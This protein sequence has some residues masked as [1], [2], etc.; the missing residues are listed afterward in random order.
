MVYVGTQVSWPQSEARHA[1]D[2]RNAKAEAEAEASKQRRKVQNRKNQ[3]A[4]R[5][6]APRS[7][8]A[9]HTQNP[10]TGL[11]LKGGDAGNRKESRPFLVKRW[12]LDE[13]DPI[14]SQE[15]SPA[16]ERATT[17]AFSHGPPYT[18][19]GISAS[20]AKRT[21]VLRESLFTTTHIQP[22]VNLDIQ[23]FTFPF[24][25]DHLLHLIHYNVCR[26]L[27][28]NMRTLN[29][30]PADSTICTIASPCRDDTTLYPLR[31]DIPSSLIPTAFQQT[32]DHST[33]INV[34]PFPRVREN[35]IRYEGSF[36][37]WE[38]LQDLVGDLLK[39]T[40]DPRQR[41]APTSVKVSRTPQPL[42]FL[43]GTDTDEVTAGRKGLIVWGEPHEMRSWEATPGFLA[44]WAWV[45]EGCDELMEISNHWRM[46]R[47]GGTY[48]A[49]DVEELS[50]TTASA[51]SVKW[52][53][54]RH[55]R[56]LHVFSVACQSNLSLV[57]S[58]L[59]ML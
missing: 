17:T 54:K 30:L 4:R 34:I 37:P 6:S 14:P 41:D 29:T 51:C 16:S 55:Y 3:R 32:H 49:R 28:T 38:I 35:L 44:K 20:T 18:D 33:W 46:K 59:G 8:N 5:E 58:I 43:S 15:I 21:V 11:R 24:S 23:P 25:S 9:F 12:H 31:S 40:P 57:K 19:A 53:L 48:A 10:R 2:D 52:R 39:S 56:R 36:D 27:I 7:D 1:V 42:T 26:A 47:G 45:A 13:P 50:A 22:L